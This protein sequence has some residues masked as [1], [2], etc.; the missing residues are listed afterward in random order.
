MRLL[1]VIDHKDY[2]PNGAA[3]ERPSVRAIIVRDGRAAMVYSQK[4]DY[5]KFPGG[6]PEMGETHEQALIREVREETGLT[7]IPES[8][9]PYGYV[10][11]IQKGQKEPV[12]IQDNYY[13]FC[14]VTD[15]TGAQQLDAYEQEEGFELRWLTAKE[16]AAIN[17]AHDRAGADAVM[18]VERE[19]RVLQMLMDEGLA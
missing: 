6:G 8:I 11:R 7:V 18:I 3:F 5:V 2:D 19:A 1:Y 13:Y 12:F 14:A 17:L 4:Y 9:R 16:A 15:G 10:H